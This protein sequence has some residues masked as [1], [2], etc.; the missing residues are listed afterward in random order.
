MGNLLSLLVHDAML[1]C[2]GFRFVCGWGL[3]TGWNV[4]SLLLADQGQEVGLKTCAIFGGVAQQNFDQATFARAKM[5]L[6]ASA[7]KT[8]QESNRLLS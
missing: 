6:N 3:L 1:R 2:R 4:A 8:V 7:R 5:S